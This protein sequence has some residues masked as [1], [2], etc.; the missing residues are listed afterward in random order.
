MAKRSKGSKNFGWFKARKEYKC[1]LTGRKIKVGDDY[2]R[3]NLPY[4]G[5]LHFHRSCKKADIDAYVEG[6]IGDDAL[7]PSFWDCRAHT[8]SDDSEAAHIEELW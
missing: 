8:A 1:D 6:L 3:I 7:D 2:Y 5:I 4:S